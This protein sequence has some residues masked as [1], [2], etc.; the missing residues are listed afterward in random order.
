[1]DAA[2][3]LFVDVQIDR[4]PDRRRGCA[5]A[6]RFPG[7]LKSRPE[8]FVVEEIPAYEPSGEGE[9]VF[10]WIE[11]RDAT[12]TDLVRHLER[13]LRTSKFEIGT[14][15][16]KDKRAVTR[17]W[18]SVP[19]WC[20]AS[21]KRIDSVRYRVLAESRHGN[22]LKTGHLKGNRFEIVVRNVP[23]G[24]FD[25]AETIAGSLRELGLPNYYGEQRF[26]HGGETLQLGFELLTGVKTKKDVPA[27]QRRFLVRL[28]ISAAQ[29][30]LFNELLERRLVAG[31][32]RTAQ[33]GDA[34]QKVD[35]SPAFLVQDAATE[36]ARLDAG[37]VA[38][39]GPMYGHRMLWPTGSP[40]ELERGLLAESGLTVE[41]FGHFKK[42]ASGTRR[43][44]LVGL[45]SL[46]IERTDED[47]ALRFRFEL[48][49]GAYATEVLSEFLLDPRAE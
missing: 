8:D 18:V 33:E 42:L 28:A 5:D 16:L 10:L 12:T 21:V 24:A 11:K 13:T 20:A 45:D 34:L 32:A 35:G 41:N 22:K 43:P 37:E 17:Q 6:N 1:M 47:D 27:R 49:S 46:A 19:G 31:T 14:A 2:T 30:T 7:R 48:P 23:A 3:E 38:V 36:Q 9:H 44:L 25:A 15:G 39:T 26:G 4:I 29:S 40:G